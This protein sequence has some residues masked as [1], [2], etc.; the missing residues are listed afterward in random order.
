MRIHPDSSESEYPDAPFQKVAADYPRIIPVKEW[1]D[2]LDKEA[3]ERCREE[4]GQNNPAHA[5]KHERPH[6]G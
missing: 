2:A 3:Y 5:S 1:P 4:C 6:V